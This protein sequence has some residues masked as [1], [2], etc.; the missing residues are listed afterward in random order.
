MGIKLFLLIVKMDSILYTTP[1]NVEGTSAWIDLP[2]I[3]EFG[4]LKKSL[5]STSLSCIDAKEKHI[6]A[7]ALTKI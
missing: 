7:G 2:C 1:A 5:S 3:K 6:S 4:M